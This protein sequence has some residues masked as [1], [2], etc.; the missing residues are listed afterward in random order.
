[1]LWK[2]RISTNSQGSTS[3][4]M[5]LD[6]SSSSGMSVLEL[7]LAITMLMVFTG[8]VAVVMEVTLRFMGEVE[9]PMDVSGVRICNDETTEDVANGVL[10][11][12]QRIEVLFDQL[13]HVLVQPG[14]HRSRID[15]ISGP[16]GSSP[17][18]V[19][20]PAASTSVWA[21]NDKV[22]ALPVLTFPRGYHICVENRASRGIDGE[23]SDPT[24]T[25]ATPGLYVLQALLTQ[26]SAASTPLRRLTCRPRPFCRTNNA[27]P[28][29]GN[30]S[31]VD[32]VSWVRQ[33]ICAPS[34]IQASSVAGIQRVWALCRSIRPRCDL[35][36][37]H[38]SGPAAGG[39]SRTR[40]PG[41][42]H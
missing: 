19:C 1:M 37:P 38:Q 30:S 16:L 5:A 26:L 31:L 22:P 40:R 27:T 8:V 14:I 41:D 3:K 28:L 32:T 2:G 11:D 42:P 9:C 7:L 20:T 24:N 35:S 12:R 6:D 36:Q 39:C 15:S 29:V 34:A 4:T 17:V 21:S 23:S 25:S 13:E 10:I 18:D 33:P